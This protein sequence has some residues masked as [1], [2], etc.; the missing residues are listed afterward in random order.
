MKSFV[1]DLRTAFYELS[2]VVVGWEDILIQAMFGL[3]TQ[4]HL[5]WLGSPGRAKSWVARMIFSLFPDAKTFSIQVTK[6]MLPSAI[7]GNEIIDEYIKNGREIYNLDGGIC[8]ADLVYLDEFLDGPDFLVRSINT[9]LNERVFERK[10]QKNSVPLHTGIMTTNFDRY[11]LALEAVRDRMMCKAA[12]PTV[13][14]VVGRVSMYNSYLSYGGNM[15]KLPGLSFQK[16]SE[17][18]DKIDAPD[19]VVIPDEIRL[20]HA[21]IIQIYLKERL[22]REKKLLQGN[23]PNKAIKDQDI[24]LEPVT[25]R[26][27]SKLHDFSRAAAFLNGRTIVEARDL[28]ALKYGLVTLGTNNGDEDTWESICNNYL[29]VSTNQLDRLK[30]LAVIANKIAGIQ[31]LGDGFKDV[32]LEFSGKIETYTKVTLFQLID[33]LTDRGG[34]TADLIAKELKQEIEELGKKKECSKFPWKADW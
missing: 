2:K 15:P 14:G 9:V 17:L 19:D 1:G 23:D 11:G 27:E 33:K 28:K 5:F 22:E 20:L 16:L 31:R 13:Q 7:F 18:A 3:V 30:Q 4:E 29:P 8:T 12:V 25:P 10:D 21:A 34:P 6:D 32:I 26:T 24:K